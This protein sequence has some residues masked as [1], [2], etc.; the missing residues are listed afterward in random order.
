MQSVYH[1]TGIF[2]FGTSGNA[3]AL[4]FAVFVD[5]ALTAG[6]AVFS[7]A[8]IDGGG[9]FVIQQDVDG[10]LHVLGLDGQL[11]LLVLTALALI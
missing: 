1:A 7:R 10:V 11:G 9:S 8:G 4:G 5:T 6:T 3:P 2:L